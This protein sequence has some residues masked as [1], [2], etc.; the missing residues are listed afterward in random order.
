MNN[1]IRILYIVPSLRLCNGVASYAMNYFR[2]IDKD[3]IQID[4]LITTN[5]EKSEYFD[6]IIKNG[7]NIFYIE[8]INGKKAL[9]SIKKIKG[10]FREH[11]NE[12]DIVHCHVLNSGAFY[13]HYAKKY[14]IKIR[15][16]HSH[17][18][19]TA[20]KF[21]NKLRN[22]IL[23]PISIKNANY[24]CACSEDAGNSLL[25]NKE[26]KIINN[27]ISG[28]RFLYNSEI[29]MKMRKQ[30]NIED[31]CIVI[32]NIGRLC[33]QKN[34][35]F[36]IDIF[37][38]YTLKNN[39]SKLIIVGN[40]ELENYLKEKVKEYKI[41]EKVLFLKPIN[42]IQDLYQMFDIFVFPSLYE[43][44]GIVLVEAQVSGL[45]CVVSDQVPKVAQISEAYY[46]LSLNSS[47]SE[48][49]NK[50]F[51]I[52]TEARK[53]DLENLR[54]SEFDIIEEAK[55][56]EAFYEQIYNREK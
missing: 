6:E 53:G 22:D 39:N 55:K 14:G 52:K 11:A 12:Y 8:P 28:E 18:T 5:N 4:F 41:E 44:L 38:E 10:F 16:L 7:G 17:V 35:K 51:S 19:K 1:K 23:M 13:L 20:D 54:K 26:F 40:G 3:K 29:R 56:L 27:A 37:K 31:N 49:A 32:G 45:P 24:F 9:N 21:L 2:N 25:K 42:N 36:L 33:N 30:Y 47:A 34:Q 46:N 50:I 43:G 15:I 48:W